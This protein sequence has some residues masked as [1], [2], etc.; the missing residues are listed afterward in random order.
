M[1]TLTLFA[2]LSG[3]L[4]SLA[5]VSDP[6]F[7]QKLAGDGIAI[8]PV[9]DVLLA[10]V[11]GEIIDLAESH[12]SVTLRTSEGV[13]VMLHIGQD[14]VMLRGKGFTPK[15]QR[16][17]WVQQGA[18][19]IEFEAEVVKPF[20]ANLV[21]TVII[22]NSQVVT[23]FNFCEGEV[24][25]GQDPIMSLTLDEAAVNGALSVISSERLTVPNLLGLHARPASVLAY[26]ARKFESDIRL[27]HKGRQANAKSVFGIMNLCIMYKD[28]IRFIARGPD[29]EEAIQKI[30]PMTL[31]GLG[32][33]IGRPAFVPTAKTVIIPQKRPADP[34]LLVGVPA[35]PGIVVGEVFQMRQRPIEIETKAK[36]RKKE[37]RRLDEAIEKAKVQLEALQARL[38]QDDERDKAAIF[39]AHEALLEDPELLDLTTQAIAGGDNAAMAWQAAYTK[40]ADRLARLENALFASRADDLRDVGLRVLRN[41]TGAEAEPLLLSTNTI[42]V[43][44]DISLS[45]VAD[46]DPT[47][48]C[49]FCT[50][51]GGASSHLTI[52]A[53]SLDIP[54]VSGIDPKAL[55]IPNG[56]TV[57]LDGS[58]GTLRLNPIEAKI[59]QVRQQQARAATVQQANLQRAAEPAITIDGHRLEIGANIGSVAEVDHVIHLG[60]EGVGLLRSEFLF[61]HHK[62]MPGEDEQ[63]AIYR[64]MVM[65]LG[66]QRPLIIRTLDIG[67]DK[68]SPYLSIPAEKNP[69]LGERGIRVGLSR[70]G[71]LHTQLRAILRASVA[72]NIRVTFPMIATLTEWRAAKAMLEQERRKLGVDPI[73]VGIMV[74]VPAAAITAAKFANEVDFFSVGTNDL[75]Q[76]TLAMDRGHPKLAPQVD[77]LSPGV[78][79]LIKTVV[80]AAHDRGKWVGVCGAVA[81]DPQG[82]PLLVGLGVDELSM[83]VPSIPRIKA[84]IRQLNL[85]KCRTLVEK[86]MLLDTATEIRAL[87]YGRHS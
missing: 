85:S 35:S 44:E 26:L 22:T 63:E 56:T 15:V 17:D 84:Q 64:D 9:D 59:T 83:S 66:E 86:A 46:L 70:P 18:P 62:T 24:V 11:D 41:L 71:I 40:Q 52:M 45:E 72:G 4:I 25:A 51:Q 1:M 73:Q 37:L 58:K 53:H 75:T 19:L 2:P 79:I 67:A 30:V 7:S 29:A 50:T 31:Q 87:D 16:G 42:L 80:E 60:G 81:A 38:S 28:P 27:E 77:S 69:F 55:D 54:A 78:L 23:Q 61:L 34:H 48:V 10:P 39:A 12:H 76:Y 68:P 5:Q 6:T 8:D 47:Y 32:E 82:V 74:E 33:D 65:R 20:A 3:R 13:E 57:I 43:A 21:T 36:K 14:T 49:G